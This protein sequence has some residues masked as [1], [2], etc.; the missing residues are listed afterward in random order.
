MMQIKSV[1]NVNHLGIQK[2]APLHQGISMR[3]E[4][5]AKAL[6]EAIEASIA[7]HLH[8]LGREHD[9]CR[10]IIPDLSYASCSHVP[11]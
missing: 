7:S 2:A 11:H 6:V 10:T 5:N 1:M 8:V 4:I 3:L 9:V